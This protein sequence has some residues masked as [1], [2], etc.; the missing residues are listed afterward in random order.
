[1][2]WSAR[3]MSH[4]TDRISGKERTSRGLASLQENKT[5]VDT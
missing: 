2:N 4:I 1:M 5:M 3:I